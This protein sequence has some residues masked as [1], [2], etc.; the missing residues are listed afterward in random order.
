[1]ILRRVAYPGWVYR[2]D[3]GP[4]QRVLK[5][6]GGIQ[7]VPLAGSGT[8]RVETAYRPTGLRAAAIV[9]LAVLGAAIMVLC[10]TGVMTRLC[11]ART[12]IGEPPPA[13]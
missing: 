7:G 9:S 10:G 1:M 6:D 5:V 3:D 8:S 4:W 13:G 11:C 2:I 12:P